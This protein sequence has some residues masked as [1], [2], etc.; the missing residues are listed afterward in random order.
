MVAGDI[1]A[2]KKVVSVVDEGV[3]ICSCD[4]GRYLLCQRKYF[5]NIRRLCLMSDPRVRDTIELGI[6]QICIFDELAV[7]IT[8]ITS[9]CQYMVFEGR[10]IEA[11]NIS[12]YQY[13]LSNSYC[14]QLIQQWHRC[15]NSESS[16]M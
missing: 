5:S 15:T 1:E 12:K 10:G 7:I 4:R 3:S 11:L 13:C 9:V 8:I 14:K 6:A 16:M 2:D